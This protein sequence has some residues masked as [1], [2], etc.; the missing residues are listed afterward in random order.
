MWEGSLHDDFSEV[1]IN[2]AASCSADSFIVRRE[3]CLRSAQTTMMEIDK[4]KS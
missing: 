2:Q 1:R 3:Q 4:D